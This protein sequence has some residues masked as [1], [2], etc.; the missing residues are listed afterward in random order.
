MTI[1]R[2]AGS[3]S[4]IVAI[5]VAAVLGF[6]TYNT[7]FVER[8]HDVVEKFFQAL[9]E[10]D[11]NTC[12]ETVDPKYEKL[13]NVS[14]K[15]VGKLF[16][17]TLRDMA[18]LFPFVVEFAK[19]EGDFEDR[20]FEIMDIVSEDIRGKTATVTVI[21]DIKD[22]KGRRIDGAKGYVYLRK[23]NAGWRIVDMK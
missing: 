14:S 21:I 20:F 1:H 8:P 11:I 15:V 2:N 7:F 19:I 22:E 12:M 17:I 23:F 4:L 16:G 10:K 13:Y 5:L 18:D 6:F 3:V 9:N